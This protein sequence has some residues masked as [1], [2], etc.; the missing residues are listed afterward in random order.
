MC[1]PFTLCTADYVSRLLP[2]LCI[3]YGTEKSII[4]CR[5]FSKPYDIAVHLHCSRRNTLNKMERKKDKRFV[6]T[7]HEEIEAKTIKPQIQKF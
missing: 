5:V 4:A 6:E 7:S 3:L 1:C 2:V